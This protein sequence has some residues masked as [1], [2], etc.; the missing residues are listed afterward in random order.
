MSTPFFL[1]LGAMLLLG[2]IALCGALK[3]AFDIWVHRRDK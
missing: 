1:I 3:A 2:F